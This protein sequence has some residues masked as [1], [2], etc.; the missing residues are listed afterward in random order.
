M[1]NKQ[2]EE[3]IQVASNG[4]AHRNGHAATNGY[5]ARATQAAADEELGFPPVPVTAATARTVSRGRLPI[6]DYGDEP[7]CEDTNDFPPLRGRKVTLRVVSRGRAP[8]NF[9][10]D[11]DGAA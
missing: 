4:D 5:V 6:V 10:P 8:H 3:K 11:E 9:E 2:L 1:Q 7:L